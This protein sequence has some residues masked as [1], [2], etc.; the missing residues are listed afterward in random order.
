MAS[1]SKARPCWKTSI[2]PP[3]R[4]WPKSRWAANAKSPWPWPPPRKP[5]PSGPACRPGE[6]ARIMRRLGDLIERHVPELAELETDDTGLPIHQTSKQLIPRASELLFLFRSRHAHQQPDLPGRFDHAQLHAAAAGGRVRA[7]LALERAADDGHLE[8]GA[9]PGAGQHRGAEDVGAVAHD[10]RPARP[11]GAGGRRA[12]RRAQHRAWPWLGSRRR[13][14]APSRRAHHFLHRRHRHRPAHRR[15]RRHQAA[16]DGAGRQV[17]RAGVR[18]RRPAARAGRGA[19]H[20]LLDQRRTLHRRLARLRAALDLRPLRPR[21]RRA[22]RAPDRG[23]PA[24][25]TPTW[26]R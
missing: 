1:P 6:R 11:A 20:H 26:A 24:R 5:S 2:P 22:R 21:V 19:V 23:R 15:T 8:G 13:A 12:Q 9:L 18:G 3:A 4:C 17:A 10:R 16:V 25:R 7:D 14:G